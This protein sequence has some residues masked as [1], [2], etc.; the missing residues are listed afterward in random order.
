V[1][2]RARR[3][4]ILRVEAD[5]VIVAD[6]VTQ[7]EV[8]AQRRQAAGHWQRAKEEQGVTGEEAGL[9]M[10]AAHHDRVVGGQQGAAAVEAAGAVD[11]VADREQGV[12]ALS[13]EPGQDGLEAHVLAMQV[14]DRG[15][16]AE[17][18]GGWRHARGLNTSS[19]RRSSGADDLR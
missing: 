2:R 18:G 5:H 17:R 8:A 1:G 14:A 12:D 19:G 3:L 15:E 16:A 13:R 6:A 11:E 9:V 10:V 7:H 4:L